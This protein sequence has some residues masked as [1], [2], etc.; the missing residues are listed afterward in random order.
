MMG[1]FALD[2][3]F[4]IASLIFF[5]HSIF[6]KGIRFPRFAGFRI[7]TIICPIYG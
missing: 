2:I 5:N 7:N 3:G 6:G 4:N 1:K